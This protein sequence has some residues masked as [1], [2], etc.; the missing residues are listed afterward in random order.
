MHANIHAIGL[1][2][3]FY[4]QLAICSDREEHKTRKSQW[5]SIWDKVRGLYAKTLSPVAHYMMWLC[6][7]PRTR[8]KLHFHFASVRLCAFT[9]NA[10]CHYYTYIHISCNAMSRWLCH[11]R[12]SPTYTTKPGNIIF[13]NHYCWN[14]WNINLTISKAIIH[15]NQSVLGWCLRPALKSVSSSSTS[16]RRSSSKQLNDNRNTSITKKCKRPLSDYGFSEPIFANI[17]SF[18]VVARLKAKIKKI[19]NV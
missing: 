7:K 5:Y 19:I 17:C 8:T 16:S 13:F 9:S 14:N 15:F 10:H 12:Q 18:R 3:R 4:I 6:I 2:S 1:L 11:H